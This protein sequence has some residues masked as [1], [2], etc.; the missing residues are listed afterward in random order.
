[1]I[2][3]EL[4]EFFWGANLFCLVASWCWCCQELSALQSSRPLEV[5]PMLQPTT[6][7]TQ[8]TQGSCWKTLT[9]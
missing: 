6:T 9:H 5:K 8:G 3:D 1:M 2:C 7:G 4:W